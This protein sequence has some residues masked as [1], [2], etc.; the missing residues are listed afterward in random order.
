MNKEEYPWTFKFKCT[1]CNED[2]SSPVVIY[3]KDV[4]D[5]PNS[6]GTTNLVM[7]CKLCASVGT[8]DLDLK[9]VKPLSNV[10]FQPLITLEARGWE[11][12][13]FM[14]RDGFKAKA[15]S[16]FEDID[17]SDLEWTDYDETVGSVEIMEIQTKI[18]RV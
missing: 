16:V 3:G 6:R 7:K 2:N 15:H 9:S 18:T 5:I 10:G 13:E 4:V 11:P 14:P 1:K 17:L 12:M 8:V